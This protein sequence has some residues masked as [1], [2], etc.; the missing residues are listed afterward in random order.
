M[1]SVLR[2]HGSRKG[3]G[4]QCLECADRGRDPGRRIQCSGLFR[5]SWDLVSKVVSRITPLSTRITPIIAYV[6]S[7]MILSEELRFRA[8]GFRSYA[9]FLETLSCYSQ[10]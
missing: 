5:G 2:V 3:V 10:L 4:I 7:L 8:L 6:L 9:S 1:D